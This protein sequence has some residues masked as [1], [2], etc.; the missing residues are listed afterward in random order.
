[1]A[2]SVL[3][4][5]ILCPRV[6]LGSTLLLTTAAGCV[7]VWGV[8]GW[9]WGRSA[10]AVLM[11]SSGGGVAALYT[12][13]WGVVGMFV[14]NVVGCGWGTCVCCMVVCCVGYSILVPVGANWRD[15]FVNAY[16][17]YV[18]VDAKWSG[19]CVAKVSLGPVG[20]QL[21]EGVVL[22]VGVGKLV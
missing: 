10:A 5:Q 8:V 9:D 15:C 7:W 19:G 11:D 14:C 12:G 17:L 21:C 13:K 20:I 4:V 1:M 22:C 3:L 6:T 2:Y 18:P 16:I